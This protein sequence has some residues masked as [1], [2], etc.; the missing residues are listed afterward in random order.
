MTKLTL[1]DIVDARAYEREREATRDRV[2]AL[3]RR[4]RVAVGDIV[5]FVFENR[6]TRRSR[7]TPAFRRNWIPITRSFPWPVSFR[8]RC[9]LS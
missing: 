8:P 7:P 3:K 2:M 5:T 9:S 1:D 4:R 6:E